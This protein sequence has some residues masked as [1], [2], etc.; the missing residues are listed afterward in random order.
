[1]RLRP[2]EHL[3]NH[4]MHTQE[5][6]LTRVFLYFTTDQQRKLNRQFFSKPNWN[7]TEPAVF[8]KTEPYLKNPFLTSLKMHYTNLLLI[9]LLTCL[10]IYL[11]TY[12]SRLLIVAACLSRLPV[13][14]LYSLVRHRHATQALL[15]ATHVPSDVSACVTAGLSSLSIH[16]ECLQVN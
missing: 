8:L 14:S 9:Y 3:E 4:K 2:I 13:H 12:L 16:A 5:R 6:Q 10:L 11:L 7:R 1:M 15:D